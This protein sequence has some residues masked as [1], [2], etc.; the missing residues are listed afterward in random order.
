MVRAIDNVNNTDPTPASFTW[1]VDATAPDTTINTNPSNPSN[2]ASASFT[3]SGMDSGGST[4]ASFECKLDGGSFSA[5]TSPQNYTGLSD[6]SHTFMV[7]AIDGVGNA[8][9]SPASYTWVVD[10]TAPDTTINTNPTNPSNSSSASFTFSGTD[11]GSGVASFECKLDGGSFSACTSPQNYSSLAD[12]SHTFEVRAIDNSDNPDAT[13]AS[14][15]WTVDTAPPDT[16]IDTNPANPT[17]STNA[18]FTFH[19]TDSGTGVASFECKLDAGSFAACTSPK[20]YTGLSNGSHTFQVRAVDSIDNVDASPASFTWTVD[21]TPP[22]VSINQAMGQSDPANGMGITIHFT[23]V[24]SEPVTGFTNGDVVIGGTAGATTVVVTEIGPM[25][26]TIYDVAV[27][28]MTMGGTVMVSIPANKAQDA[29]GNGN[30]ASSSTDNT[31]TYVPN[32][33]PTANPDNYSTTQDTPLTVSAPGVLG[34]DSDPD[35]GN[36]ITAVLVSG[37][38]NAAAF[39][40]NANG[41][42]NYTPNTGFTGTD[43]FTYKAK[44]NFNAE[45]SV[46]TVTLSVKYRFDWVAGSMFSGFTEQG[47]NQVTAGSNVAV[48]FTLYGYKGDPYSQPPTSVPISCSTFAPTGP[49]TVINRFTP[50]PYYSSL[51]D[52]YQTTWQTQTSWKFTCRQL[53]LYFNDGTTRSLKFYFK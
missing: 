45:S 30:N 15:T 14:F 12:G 37:P 40:L 16:I 8:D 47:L 21:I 51:Y 4:V 44:D 2:S 11:G 24:F 27:S 13:P 22:S 31:V 42:F 52:F 20:N 28:G 49:A 32:T 39:A 41:S 3:F 34:N 23:A 1:N 5:C 35:A 29:A 7:R 6:G 9:Q 18:S 25:N 19:G 48:R 38:T 33:P 50:D 17:N 10:S 46:V 36:T 53:T 43:S 26:G